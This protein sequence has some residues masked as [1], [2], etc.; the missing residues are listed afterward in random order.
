M[1]KGAPPSLFL[2]AE[3]GVRSNPHPHSPF[4]SCPST[5][6][7]RGGHG[8]HG[9]QPGTFPSTS[10]AQGQRQLITRIRFPKLKAHPQFSDSG[11]EREPSGPRK[12]GAGHGRRAG[13]EAIPLVNGAWDSLLQWGPRS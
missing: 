5:L 10:G 7:L 9:W 13:R 3:T 8:G 12:E 1:G 2:K 11:K 6:S 4:P